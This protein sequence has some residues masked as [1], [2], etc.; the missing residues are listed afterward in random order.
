MLGSCAAG[1]ATRF[2][3]IQTGSA[4]KTGLVVFYGDSPWMPRDPSDIRQKRQRSK[5]QADAGL[6]F[7]EYFYIIKAASHL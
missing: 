3:L 4:L 2:P 6:Q 5:S 1:E 7:I